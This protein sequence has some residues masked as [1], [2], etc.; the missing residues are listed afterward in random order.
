MADWLTTLGLSLCLF[1]TARCAEVPLQI[2]VEEQHA[3][4]RSATRVEVCLNG[5][6]RFC[7]IHDRERLSSAV[8]MQLPPLPTDGWGTIRVPGKW[9]QV[10]G[11]EAADSFG[12]PRDWTNACRGWYQ[13]T[14]TVPQEMRDKRLKLHFGAV[15]VYAEVLVNGRS[16][17]RHL[18]GVT[19]F[20]VDITDA[21][22]PDG[23][24]TLTV[25]VVNEAAVYTRPPKSRYDFAARAPIYY[26][27]SQG[28]AGIWQD[29]LLVGLPAVHVDN[30]FVKTS[31][32]Q[33]KITAE[34]EL[35]NE[36]DR[37][38][39]VTVEA[40]VE[41][42]HAVQAKDLG[43]H[44]I[45][46]PAGGTVHVNLESAWS[47]ARLWSPEAPNLYRLHTR[48]LASEKLVDEHYQRFGFR[49][50]WIEGRNFYLNGRRLAL[51]GA[52]HH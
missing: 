51:L 41:D 16:V 29:V 32:R 36:S 47:D 38:Q 15:L 14:F 35:H 46:I 12:Y 19:P 48:V 11:N 49:E 44:P 13:R 24:N 40:V 43:R 37:D 45:T 7:P 18:G 22:H 26:S 34:I 6:W 33:H 42:L 4:R 28:S 23:Q 52:F 10:S 5:E 1:V 3:A 50:F 2:S 27:Y 17:G 30:V 9:K 31:F 39:A 21:V 8:L 25:Y 20:D